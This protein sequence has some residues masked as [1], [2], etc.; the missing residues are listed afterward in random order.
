MATGKPAF[1][2]SNPLTVAQKIVAGSYSPLPSTYSPLF[3]EMVRRLL[4]VD[5][6]A[7]PDI[8]AVSSLISP[9]LMAELDR[10]NISSDR[11]VQ[12]LAHSEERHRREK[13]EWMREKQIWRKWMANTAHAHTQQRSMSGNGGGPLGSSGSNS[14]LQNGF[15][16]EPSSAA[17]T[18]ANSSST[19]YPDDPS[20]NLHPP[21]SSPLFRVSTSQLRPT[22]HDPLTLLLSQLHK[23]V[24]ISQ[25]PP[26]A[27]RDL[28]RSV[29]VKYKQSLFAR[30]WNPAEFKRELQQVVSGSQDFI[31]PSFE[32]PHLD[33]AALL[34]SPHQ[35]SS[36]S[37]AASGASS[38]A[39]ASGL[40]HSLTHEDLQLMI[41]QVLEEVGYYAQQKGAAGGA[42]ATAA[43]HGGEN[44]RQR[45]REE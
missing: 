20:S 29:I 40:A 24:H 11:L 45:S 26:K 32:L 18:P 25:L 23:I 44:A 42:S 38:T 22:S 7:R 37:V 3:H 35:A 12:Q 6:Q 39:G 31:D 8:L 1:A 30:P 33:A 36:A 21:T 15:D 34:T 9:L 43:A 16:G 4:T 2:G 13:E 19:D 28:K 27:Q 14:N 10:V 17:A 5:P 41:E